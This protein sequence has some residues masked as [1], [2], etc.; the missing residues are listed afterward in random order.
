[1]TFLQGL[2]SFGCQTRCAHFTTKTPAKNGYAIFGS[3][4]R[5]PMEKLNR[6]RKM[7]NEILKNTAEKI[8]IGDGIL[9]PATSV[10]PKLR[11]YLAG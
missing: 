2:P 5:L 3:P 8:E 10:L 7:R 11:H 4:A 9:L 6:Y 1:M